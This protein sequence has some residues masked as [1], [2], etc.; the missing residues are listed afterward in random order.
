[1][2]PGRDHEITFSGS[3]DD[4]AL[5][6]CNRDYEAAPLAGTVMD[7]AIA[8]DRI[9]ARED[10]ANALY[11]SEE[12]PTTAYDVVDSL[13]PDLRQQIWE[14]FLNFDWEGTS[15][16]EEFSPRNQFA[17]VSYEEDWSIIRTIRARSD[18]VAEVLGE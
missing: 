11:K 14:A 6:V 10:F 5:G 1:M 18:E 4:S 15:L 3:H 13:H 7:R 2:P 9:P 12:L 8:A 17:P 16:L